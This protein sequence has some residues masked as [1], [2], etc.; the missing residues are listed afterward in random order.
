MNKFI[1]SVWDF[2]DASLRETNYL[3]HNFFRWYGKLIPQIPQR[4]INLY[5]NKND[6]VLANFNGSGTVALEALIADRNI[7]GIDSSPLSILLTKVKISW[8]IPPCDSFLDNLQNLLNHKRDFHWDE[9]DSK[10]YDKQ[11]FNDLMIIK[12]YILTLNKEQDIEYYLLALSSII[13]KVSKI[14]SRCINHMVVDKNKKRVNVFQEFIKKVEEMNNSMLDLKNTYPQKKSAKI[15][16]GDA[17]NLEQVKDETIDLIISHPPYLGYINYS[18]IFK[19][20]NKLIGYSYDTIKTNDISTTS[21]TKYMNNMKKI[22]DEMYRVS[23]IGKY[24]CVIVGDNRVNGDLIPTFS[25][26]ISYANSIGLKLKDIYIWILNQKAGMSVKRRGN[27][28]DHNYI[29]IFQK[30]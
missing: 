8:Y 5:S 10:W 12:E 15:I 14:D 9:V 18:N 11:T 2:K 27:H 7:V 21:L 13:R 24:V 4:L 17:R 6:N 19:L 26:F 22:F 29:L 16:Y 20:A 23:K 1:S 25:Y 28:V 30:G 3:T